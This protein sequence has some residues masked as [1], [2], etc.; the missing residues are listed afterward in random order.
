MRIALPSNGTD[1]DGHFGHC[2]AFT[3]F[4]VDDD[5]KIVAEETLTPPPGCG[6]KSSIIPQLSEK[7]VT[8]LLA[9][10]MGGGAVNLMSQ[11]GIQTVR[12]CSGNVRSVTEAW[13]AEEIQDAGTTCSAHGEDG[14]PGH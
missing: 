11:H 10:N 14:C 9:G 8:V 1:V 7:G 13:L 12:G 2:Q 5:K 3:I 6:C 4:T